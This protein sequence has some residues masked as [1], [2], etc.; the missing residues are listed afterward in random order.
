M[1]RTVTSLIPH[2]AVT[3]VLAIAV[4]SLTHCSSSCDSEG[5]GDGLFLELQFPLPTNEPLVVLVTVG[6]EQ[7][8][9]TYSLQGGT[10]GTQGID[11]E[12][13]ADGSVARIVFS[14]QHPERVTLR[15]SNGT[16][17]VLLE[18]TVTPTYQEEPHPNPDACA[19]TCRVAF[20]KL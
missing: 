5:C 8:Q 1:R 18:Q 19:S 13:Q 15:I 17:G 11:L 14:N 7:R 16:D 4:C 12:A 3:G 6:G 9:C 2:L 20:E 10:C